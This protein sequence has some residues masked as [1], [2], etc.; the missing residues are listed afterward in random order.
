M[1]K[2]R[3]RVAKSVSDEKETILFIYFPGFLEL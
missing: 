1:A 3:N 2:A